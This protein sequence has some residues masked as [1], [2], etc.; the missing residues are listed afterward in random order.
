VSRFDGT[1]FVHFT[2]ADEL[3][4]RN[5]ITVTNTPDGSLWFGAIYGGIF[6][7][8]PETFAHFD[9]ADGL[10][11]PDSA[12]K[13]DSPNAGAALAAPD[14]TLWFASGY[15]LDGPKGLVRFDGREFEQI[16]P[17]GTNSVTSLALAT[18]QT[19]WVGITRQESCNTRKA[20]LK[21]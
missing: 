12:R 20:V 7:Y 19:I 11:S 13:A 6:R 17:S 3:A 2:A 4:F 16:L 1:N 14:G 5:V 8:H 10:V 9:V 21:N 15:D 18:D